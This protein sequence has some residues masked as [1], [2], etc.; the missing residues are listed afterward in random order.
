MLIL[1]LQILQQRKQ[2]FYFTVLG[3]L[4]FFTQS[5]AFLSSSLPPTSL[6]LLCNNL[7]QMQ[8]E[9]SRRDEVEGDFLNGLLLS[10]KEFNCGSEL[11]QW[12]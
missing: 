1:S 7:G 2:E 4:F 11:F 8:R 3:K 6:P 9:V 5:L 10:F 12:M